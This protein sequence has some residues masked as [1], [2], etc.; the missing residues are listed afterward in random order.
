MHARTSG[1]LAYGV[2][3]ISLVLVLTLAAM[4]FLGD[5]RIAVRDVVELDPPPSPEVFRLAGHIFTIT[6][7]VV[8]AG[9]ADRATL[10]A[11]VPTP[12]VSVIEA[13]G[14]GTVTLRVENLPTRVRLAAS[15]PVEQE[16]VGP[17]RTLR[18]API[19]TRHLGFVAPTDTVTFTVL[20][21][22]GDSAIFAEAL[23]A[24]ASGQA[25]FLLHVGDLIYDDTQMPNIEGI[26][27]QSPLPVFV[28]RGNHDYRNGTRIAFMRALGPPYYSFRIGSATFI[29]LDNADDYLPRFWRRST[30]Y[31]WWTG[32]VGQAREGPLFVGMHKPPFDR[33]GDPRHYAPMLDHAFA[34]QLMRDFVQAG[35]GAVLTGHIHASYL[36]VRDGIPYVVSGEGFES[37]G[38]PDGHRMAWVRVR[39]WDV[40]IEQIRIRKR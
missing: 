26:L 29:I 32:M 23:R 13:A 11:W 3:G 19:A 10:W 31:R 1:R 37:P 38:D 22:T 40:A 35:V 30:Q 9:E 4:L 12:T 27:R 33:R 39:G 36:W 18:F 24:A 20:G 21:D 15:G 17:I 7:A 34:R 5:L 6:G 28:A 14:P 2:T 8:R 25:D 16:Q